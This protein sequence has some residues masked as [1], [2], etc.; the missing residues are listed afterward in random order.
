MLICNHNKGRVGNSLFRLF[1]NIIFLTIHSNITNSHIVDGYVHPI[2]L[3]VTDDYFINL[4]NKL[5]QNTPLEKI[6]INTNIFFD[7]YYQ[8]DKIFVKYKAD[9]INYIET[10]P[11]LII[12]TDRNENYKAIDF[13]NFKINKTFNIVVHLRLEDFINISQVID[14]NYIAIVIDKINKEYNNE[15]ICFVV[16][17]PK[18]D[19][20]YKYI[21]FFTKKYSNIV[22]ES[23]EVITDYTIMREAKV[24]VCSCSTLSWAAAILSN[25]IQKVYMPDYKN[26]NGPHQTCKQPIFNTELYEIKTCTVDELNKICGK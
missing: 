4:M 10:H 9:I 19:I 25:S 24:L 2:S 12:K 23:N 8:H 11:K 13:I 1:A 18:S 17:K 5:L 6:N 20:E 22:V 21:S 16:N 15:T 7:G 14:P 26:V 3:V